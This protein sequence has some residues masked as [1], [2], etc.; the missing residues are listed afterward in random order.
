MTLEMLEEL[1]NIIELL[2]DIVYKQGLIIEHS[3]VEE[4]VKKEMREYRESVQ[5]KID[6]GDMKM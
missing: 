3:K 1:C 5:K 4:E 6:D 2:S